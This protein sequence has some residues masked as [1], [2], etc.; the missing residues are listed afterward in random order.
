MPDSFTLHPSQFA[1]PN[2]GVIEIVSMVFYRI[3]IVNGQF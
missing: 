1:L 2:S 3:F